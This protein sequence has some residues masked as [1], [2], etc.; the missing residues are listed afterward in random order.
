LFAHE[1]R[2]LHGVALVAMAPVAAQDISP[3]SLPITPRCDWISSDNP[4]LAP[5][6]QLCESAQAMHDTLPNFICDQKTERS[7]PVPNY[8]RP[9]Y[10]KGTD[11]VTAQ[12]TYTSGEEHFSN[13][14]V[15]GQPA[16]PWVAN[17]A[18]W[19]EGEFAPLV[20]NALNEHSA[21]RLTF[22]GESQLGS[23]PVLVFNYAIE[24]KNNRTWSWRV[25]R[26]E[27]FPAYHGSIWI[28]KTTGHLRRFTEEASE[29]E[30]WV[31]YTAMSK[32]TEYAGVQISEL[33]T[34]V[35]PVRSRAVGCERGM[36][37][38]SE[39][40]L[41]FYTCRKFAA[42]AKIVTDDPRPRPD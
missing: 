22:R 42:T 12:V 1:I 7:M 23:S 33:G 37:F 25:A 8:D 34:F 4:Q 21:P 26:V 9:G 40:V 3:R 41:T 36:P 31:G 24:A 5:V 38:C 18:M 17:N 39:N 19:S 11:V 35:L 28:D 6:A 29:I 16:D 2:T 15:D 20:L 32:E 13:V 14:L 30:H 10:R 27:H